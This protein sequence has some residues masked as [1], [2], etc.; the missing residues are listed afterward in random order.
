MSR[1]S[2]HSLSQTELC[3]QTLLHMVPQWT[4]LLSAGSVAGSSSKPFDWNWEMS[5]LCHLHTPQ[6]HFVSGAWG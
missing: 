6:T 2:I 4:S 1:P 3:A 5:F